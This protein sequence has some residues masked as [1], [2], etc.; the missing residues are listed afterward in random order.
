M[1]LSSLPEQPGEERMETQ[2]STSCSKSRHLSYLKNCFLNFLLTQS[3]FSKY[4]SLTFIVYYLKVLPFISVSD[5]I[6]TNIVRFL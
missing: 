1:A 3:L 5:T 4:I 6:P 2:V